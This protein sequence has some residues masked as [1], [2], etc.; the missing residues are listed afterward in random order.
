ME[1]VILWKL[2]DTANTFYFVF[3]SLFVDDEL[4]MDLIFYYI[5]CRTEIKSNKFYLKSKYL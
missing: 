3:P 4:F 2:P 1:I 5:L